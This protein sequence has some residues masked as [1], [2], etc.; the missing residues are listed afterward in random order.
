MFVL[1]DY[2][3]LEIPELDP[4]QDQRPFIL[5]SVELT[6]YAAIKA[7]WANIA[8]YGVKNTTVLEV[9]CVGCIDFIFYTRSDGFKLI[10][11][12]NF[13]FS[14]F[15]INRAVSDMYIKI[16]MPEVKVTM[17]THSDLTFGLWNLKPSGTITAYM[18][19]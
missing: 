12:L 5:Q 15:D 8:V 1:L 2:P 9:R 3:G 19:T 10:F 11:F 13:L 6:Q 4:F 14:G 7:Y 16:T 18:G 17:D